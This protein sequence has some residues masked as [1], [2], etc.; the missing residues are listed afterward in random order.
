[1]QTNLLDG[2][3]LLTTRYDGR[4]HISICPQRYEHFEIASTSVCQQSRKC[5]LFTV[6]CYHRFDSVEDFHRMFRKLLNDGKKF[7]SLVTFAIYKTFFMS[8]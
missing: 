2:Q 7:L 8:S 4:L 1:M 6:R 3:Y 5:I